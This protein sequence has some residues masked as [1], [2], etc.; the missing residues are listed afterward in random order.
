MLPEISI[1][2]RTSNRR[3][4][5]SFSAAEA[6]AEEPVNRALDSKRKAKNLPPENIR[7]LNILEL[8]QAGINYNIDAKICC[9]D[10]DVICHFRPLI[11]LDLSSI[12]VRIHWL[13]LLKL[14]KNLK[15]ATADEKKDQK[16]E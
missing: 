2:M 14:A 16:I 4:L 9:D 10:K 5:L 6:I 3:E 12:G 13:L 11:H 7:Y 8:L 15:F 1:I